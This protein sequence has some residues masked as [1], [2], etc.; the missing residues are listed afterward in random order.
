[1]CKWKTLSI[2][3]WKGVGLTMTE[4]SAR[5]RP[6]TLASFLPCSLSP[7][8]LS[9]LPHTERGQTRPMVG[10]LLMYPR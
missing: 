5:A 7:P 6:K 8:V 1:M 4:K 10:L 9:V 3:K 2:Y